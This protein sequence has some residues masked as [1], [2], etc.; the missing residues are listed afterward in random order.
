MDNWLDKFNDSLN[1]LVDKLE[2]WLNGIIVIIPNL[3]LAAVVLTL[4]IFLS[5]YVSR[6]VSKAIRRFSGHEAVNRLVS[7]VVTT[8]FIL[9]II[10][11]V[12]SILKLDTA[13]QSLLAGAGV[14][15]L[16][17]GLALQD[18]ITNLFSG[19]MMSTKKSFHIGDLVET[20]DYFGTI[21]N[22]NLRAT[23]IRTT[24]GQEVV[25]P[26]KTVYQ[27][28]LKN[29]SNTDERRIDLNCGVSY[30]DDLE[31]AKSIAIEA[32]KRAIEPK[33]AAR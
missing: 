8:L 20:N 13:L 29:Y 17:I 5:R 4:G 10:F 25:I 28:P 16:A 12:L 30:G 1:N 14:A 3:V 18:P 23:I 2:S 21:S 11:I 15:G 27:N 33:R 32:V 19:V 7:S 24:Q 6:Y 26:N 22:I 31:K 9:L